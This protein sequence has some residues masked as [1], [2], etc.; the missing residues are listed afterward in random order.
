MRLW[1][2]QTAD[3]DFA[4]AT[5]DISLS[6]QYEHERVKAAALE[7]QQRLRTS[8]FVWCFA[9][10]CD[11]EWANLPCF[12]RRGKWELNVP[13]YGI[14]RLV[15]HTVWEKLINIDGPAHAPGQC[16]P[17]WA[18]LFASDRFF[19]MSEDELRCD[20]RALQLCALVLLPIHESWIVE[21]PKW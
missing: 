15:K 7:L 18:D 2:W 13:R 6:D 19:D 12:K 16:E 9:R 1:T 21:Q 14:I 20:P 8:N 11:S 3:F 4:S 17:L 10:K 5:R